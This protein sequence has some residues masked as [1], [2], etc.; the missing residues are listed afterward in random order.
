MNIPVDFVLLQCINE[1]LQQCQIQVGTVF[2]L[3][4]VRFVNIHFTWAHML[5]RVC[6]CAAVSQWSS[7]CSN[8]RALRPYSLD[9]YLS[10]CA[11]ILYNIRYLFLPEVS[12]L[13][14]EQG[15]SGGRS[16]QRRR[17]W[18]LEFSGVCLRLGPLLNERCSILL[19]MLLWL[20]SLS[21]DSEECNKT[22][23]LFWLFA[24]LIGLNKGVFLSSRPAFCIV[25][26]EWHLFLWS[27]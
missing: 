23:L 19:I 26:L 18:A 20:M 1:C 24:F 17:M 9:M 3:L 6:V 8:C 2:C 4:P 13:L 10:V 25:G 14:S 5:W 27:F 12:L 15:S 21:A 22:F 7:L 16:L 11:Y